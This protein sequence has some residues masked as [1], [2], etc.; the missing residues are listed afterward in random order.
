MNRRWVLATAAVGLLGAIA[1]VWALLHPAAFWLSHWRPEATHFDRRIIFGPYPV[2]PDFKALQEQ[3]VTTIISL[4]DSDLPYEKVLLDQEQAL[5]ARYGMKVANFPM[6]S[7]LGQSFGKDYVAMSKAAAETARRDPGVVYI[8][9]YLGLH[10]AENVRKLL[11]AEGATARYQGTVESGRSPDTLALDRANLA[12]MDGKPSETLRELAAITA[13]TPEA[14]LLA[15]WAHYR[16]GELDAAREAFERVARE[17]PRSADALNGLGYCA[18]R[19]GNLAEAESGF[20]RALAASPDDSAATEGLGY[21][22]WRQGRSAEARTLFE[23]VLE[24]HPDN[25]EVR[26]ILEK[27]KA[28]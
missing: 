4:L 8:H 16:L 21:V 7:I 11:E 13:P 20:K 1:G 26:A 28:P 5:A 14:T 3:G 2:E 18:L 22:R 27:L 19:G 6:A 10:R 9:C 25:T 12:F 23:N 15:G 24:R 17:Q